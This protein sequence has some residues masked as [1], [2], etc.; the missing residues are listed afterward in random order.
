MNYAKTL[1]LALLT[2][3]VALPATL[4]H[5][6]SADSSKQVMAYLE[7]SGASY[8]SLEAFYSYM[9][10][11][12][13]DT[14]AVDVHGTVSGTAPAQALQLAKSK[15]MMTFATVSNFDAM[16]FDP[17]IAHAILS[18]SKIRARAIHQMLKLVQ[19]WGYTGINIDF[20]S[21]DRTDRKAFSTFIHDVEQKMRAAGYLTVVSVPAELKDNPED[22]WTGAF[23]FASLGQSADILQV[24]TYD[25]N[26]PWG[27]PGPVAGLNW[28]EPCIVYSVSVV[29][30]SKL[31]LGIPAYGYDW[32][33]TAKT[34][35]QV[36]WK[37]IPALIS[38]TGATPQWDSA[39]SSPFFT[40]HA[41]DGSSHV[42]WYEDEKS[43]PLKS[44]L[45]VSHNLAGVSV[46]ALG[47]DDLSF[48]QAVHAGGF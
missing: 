38:K 32:N 24:M 29:A 2:A 25:E 7:G 4:V 13:T 27:A 18:D 37:D 5:A 1:C 23:D 30:P 9:N 33:M 17:K 45:A 11:M 28:V 20:E 3:M 21:V 44:S 47:Y 16:G 19:H 35:V 12:P 42:V 14:F 10:Q 22:S 41:A 48:W 31:S 34:G 36:F 26:G 46:F 8:D 15:G 6:A 43:I 39:S 40:Y